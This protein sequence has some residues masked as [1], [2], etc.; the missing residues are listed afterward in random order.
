[1][2]TS[3]LGACGYFRVQKEVTFGTP[4]TSSMTLWPIKA[5][6]LITGLT[7][8][9]E[10]S[11]LIG[12]KTKQDPDKGR[13]INA[14][15][16]VMD[17][18]PDILGLA[19]EFFLGASADTANGTA[20]D[21]VWLAKEPGQTIGT[22]FTAQQAQ[23]EDLADQ[24]DGGKITS[25][26]FDGDNTGNVQVTIEVTFQSLTQGVARIGT[27]VLPTTIPYNF[28]FGVLNIN[29]ATAS[30]FDQSINSFSLTLDLSYDPERFKFGSDEV[31]ELVF[32]NIPIATLTANI[33]A[34]KQFIDFARDHEIFDISLTVTSTEFAAGATVFNT[35]IEL[36]GCRLA[37]ETEIPNSFERLSM[38]IE[39]DC[40]YGGVTTNSSGSD[41][42][43]EILHT[44][45]T[46]SYPG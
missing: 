35:I 9:I 13:K 11:N 43:F 7:E 12:S 36:P 28:S 14:G 30:P 19:F 3:G 18:F 42:T 24:W 45:A 25:M 8:F 26:T 20:F 41:V 38:D 22:S 6:T 16:V 2:A 34:D 23:G 32:Q 10:N 1:M 4:V 39:F 29:P 31:N 5:D 44:D 46:A 33:D 40:G 15:S 21:H 37:P 17:M 27:F